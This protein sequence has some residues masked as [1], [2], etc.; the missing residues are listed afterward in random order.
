MSI[1]ELFNNRRSHAP[2]YIVAILFALLVVFG[3]I[4]LASA[5]SHLGQV[6]AQDSYFYLKHQ[7][8]YGLSLG[9]VGFLITTRI[10]YTSY[11]NKYFLLGFL[12]FTLILILMVFTPLGVTIKGAT[13]WLEFGSSYNKMSPSMLNYVQR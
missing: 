7:I 2:D 5:S 1:L 10:R 13:R 3:L 4:M 6:D 12:I 11:N 9:I 8:Y